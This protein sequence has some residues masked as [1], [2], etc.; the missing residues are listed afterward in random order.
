MHP[1]VAKRLAMEISAAEVP[2][3]APFLNEKRLV[4]RVMG[5]WWLESDGVVVVRE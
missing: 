3:L 1:W 2:S 5:W 4:S